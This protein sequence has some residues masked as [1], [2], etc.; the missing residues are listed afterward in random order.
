MIMWHYFVGRVER[1]ETRQIMRNH[2]ESCRIPY[3]YSAKRILPSAFRQAHWCRFGH[4]GLDKV[5]MSKSTMNARMAFIGFRK[6]YPTY[7]LFMT[8][9]QLEMV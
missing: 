1:S 4:V 7:S 6:L 2:V 3:A 8:I 5:F 9:C